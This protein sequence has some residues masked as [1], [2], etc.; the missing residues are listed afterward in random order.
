MEKPRPPRSPC[1]KTPR[2]SL[3]DHAPFLDIAA[4]RC[5][6]R[7]HASRESPLPRAAGRFARGGLRRRRARTSRRGGAGLGRRPATRYQGAANDRPGV[8]PCRESGGAAARQ[9]PS[10]PGLL[11]RRQPAARQRNRGA[12][13]QAGVEL[14]RWRR[15]ALP[16][17]F[18]H[19]DAAWHRQGPHRLRRA[20]VLVAGLTPPRRPERLQ[21]PLR[22]LREPPPL[23]RVD[24]PRVHMAARARRA[25]RERRAPPPPARHGFADPRRP[26]RGRGR[27]ESPRPLRHRALLRGLLR[28]NRPRR[29]A[30]RRPA[31]LRRAACGRGGEMDFR[32]DARQ[33][34]GDMRRAGRHATD[35]MRQPDRRLPF[36]SA[37]SRRSAGHH[38]PVRPRTGRGSLPGVLLRGRARS[39]A[40]AD[41]PLR[42]PAPSRRAGHSR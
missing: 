26:R 12:V 9:E 3:F 7:R 39:A 23:R 41:L 28:L 31:H 25:L 24:A 27:Q 34:T 40:L 15:A 18:R 19:A 8:P 42:R 36:P 30:Y 37:A 14:F 13:D 33:A 38:R 20:L 32:G 1:L 17:P 21:G 11:R 16:H 10:A 5:R 4:I 2:L 29:F 6:H 35:D 22:P